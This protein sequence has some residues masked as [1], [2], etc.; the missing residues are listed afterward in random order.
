MLAGRLAR[1]RATV[2]RDRVVVRADLVLRSPP[3]VPDAAITPPPPPP[4]PPGGGSI[5]FSH[6]LHFAMAAASSI[7]IF[8]GSTR[9][10]LAGR[11]YLAEFT[12]LTYVT[13]SRKCCEMRV[14]QQRVTNMSCMLS[15][16]KNGVSNSTT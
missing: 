15:I 8:F 13:G 2:D 12:L 3:R 4:G 6:A 10:Y 16:L 5:R 14:S 7:S 9:L 1:R 11:K